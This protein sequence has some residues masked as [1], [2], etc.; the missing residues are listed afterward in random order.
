MLEWKPRLV[1]LMVTLVGVAAALG[2]IL[3]PDNYG[4]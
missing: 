2:F 1:L 4:W 3:R